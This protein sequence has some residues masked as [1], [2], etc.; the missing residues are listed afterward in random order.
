MSDQNI[1]GFYKVVAT[2]TSAGRFLGTSLCRLFIILRHA[3]VLKYLATTVVS[4][5]ES[6]VMG[7]RAHRARYRADVPNY[8]MVSEEC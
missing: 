6:A 1:D 8:C 5:D 7:R 2:P 3:I 4:I